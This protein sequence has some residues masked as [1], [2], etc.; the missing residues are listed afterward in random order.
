VPE[1]GVPPSGDLVTA[2]PL[3]VT[4]LVTFQLKGSAHLS[5][6]LGITQELPIELITPDIGPVTVHEEY[7]SDPLSDP[8]VHVRVSEVHELPKGTTLAVYAVTDAP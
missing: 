5:V 3:T 4:G 8:L 2:L 1:L 6:P 7:V